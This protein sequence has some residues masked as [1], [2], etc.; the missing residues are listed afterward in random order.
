LF[1]SRSFKRNP[2]R[3]SNVSF[4]LRFK[5][6]VIRRD[7][8]YLAGIDNGKFDFANLQG[9]ITNI[10]AIQN[11]NAKAGRPADTGLASRFETMTQFF[12]KYG[13]AVDTG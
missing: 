9:A 5:F 1:R 6:I 2:R 13:R 4:V 10:R 7:S 8:D 3:I 11:L 12:R